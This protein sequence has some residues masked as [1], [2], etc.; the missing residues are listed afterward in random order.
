MALSFTSYLVL[1]A[2]QDGPS[3]GYSIRQRLAEFEPG[4]RLVPVATLYATI[5]RLATEGLVELDGEEIVDG[6]ARRSFRLTR[7]GRAEMIDEADRL[8]RSASLVKVKKAKAARR[9]A[10]AVRSAVAR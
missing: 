2:L 7:Q 1:V 8:A 6:R 9:G 4:E 5:E 3:H 10:A